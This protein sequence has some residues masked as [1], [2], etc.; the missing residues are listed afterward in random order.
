MGSSRDANADRPSA[1]YGL[2]ENEVTVLTRAR[3]VD[4]SYGTIG[5]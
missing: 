3:S 1:D 5:A 4:R 2:E